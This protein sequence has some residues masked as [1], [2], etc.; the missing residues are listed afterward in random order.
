MPSEENKTLRL[1]STTKP[2]AGLQQ[3]GSERMME[4]PSTVSTAGRHT[5]A[6]ERKSKTYSL[7]ILLR[8]AHASLR[9]R[10]GIPVASGAFLLLSSAV[11]S[12]CIA[13]WVEL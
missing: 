7:S 2:I 3:A 13:L 8:D 10:R 5:Q 1:G 12:L 11:A 9:R 4:R 6:L